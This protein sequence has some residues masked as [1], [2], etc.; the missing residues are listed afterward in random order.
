MDTPDNL[1]EYTDPVL[2]DLENDKFEPDGPFYLALARRL[3]GSVLELGCGT[4]RLTVPLAQQGFDMTGLDVMPKM[5]ARAREKSRGLPIQW[6]EADVRH[7]DLRRRFGFIFES[8]ATFQHMLTRADQEAFLACARAHLSPE[9]HL[10][11]GAL[12]PAGGLLETQLDEQPWFS[13]TGPAGQ[14]VNVSG[15][16]HYDAATQVKTETAIRRW[17]T[18][19][20][21]RVERVAPLRLRYT[22]PAEMEALLGDLGFTVRERYGDYDLGAL[23]A[24]SQ[25]QLYVCQL[26]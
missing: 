1:V 5:L 13:Y 3:G 8:G 16:Q 2:Y 11:L 6:V 23:T 21:Q 18:E 17:Q 14:T 4:G 9:G 7:F 12:V 10:V 22:Y 15:T 20:G 19:E 26:A 25:H 24:E